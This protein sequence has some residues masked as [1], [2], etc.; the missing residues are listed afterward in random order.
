MLAGISRITMISSL[1]T[2][3][4]DPKDIDLL[5]TVTDEMDLTPRARFLL[6]DDLGWAEELKYSQGA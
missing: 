1:A 3:K 5:V 6:L 4:A 2:S